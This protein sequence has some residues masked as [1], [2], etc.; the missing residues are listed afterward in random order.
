MSVPEIWS[1]EFIW[2]YLQLEFYISNRKSKGSLCNSL[3]YASHGVFQGSFTMTQATFVTQVF[4]T[5][6]LF[7]FSSHFVLAHIYFSQSLIW[8]LI[9]LYVCGVPASCCC[10]H[11]T[12]LPVHFQRQM[13]QLT[14]S[15]LASLSISPNFYL[16]L[17]LSTKW[18]YLVHVVKLRESSSLD[19]FS[20]MSPWLTVNL[21]TQLLV[22]DWACYT[23]LSNQNY[24]QEFHRHYWKIAFTLMITFCLERQQPTPSYHRMYV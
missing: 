12:P 20:C 23:S 24:S 15:I 6:F 16:V 18:G 1:M 3:S 14:S 21:Y 9:L 4:A 19:Y 10:P 22:Q 8:K 5:I 7:Q 11:P 13:F 2:S 17:H